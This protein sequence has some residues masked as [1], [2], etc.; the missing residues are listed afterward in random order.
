MSAAQYIDL[1]ASDQSSALI[2]E[3]SVYFKSLI[4]SF[5]PVTAGQ[6]GGLVLMTLAK[7]RSAVGRQTSTDAV[8]CTKSRRT[9]G[10]VVITANSLIFH[11]IAPAAFTSA[12]QHPR[13]I[14]YALYALLALIYYLSPV[15]AQ[16]SGLAV[17]LWLLPS[18]GIPFPWIFETVPLYPVFAANLK[19]SF[20]KQL[21]NHLSAPSQPPAQRLRFGWQIADITRFTNLLT[22]LLTYYRALSRTHTF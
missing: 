20:T 12:L 9:P 15:S 16:V 11:V 19:P 3:L 18:F 1:T 21:S 14:N 4:T 2:S 8:D 7:S 5:S 17:F 22:Y 10:V 13:H 6:Q